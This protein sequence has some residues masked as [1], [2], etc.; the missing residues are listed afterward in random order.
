MSDANNKNIQEMME[1]TSFSSF[2][3]YMETAKEKLISD[4]DILL[5][6]E[7]ALIVGSLDYYLHQV[8]LEMIVNVLARGESSLESSLEILPKSIAESIK[9]E[10]DFWKRKD[11]LK[12]HLDD[13]IWDVPFL[14]EKGVDETAHFLGISNLWEKASGKVG[15]S[16]KEFKEIF[17]DAVNRRNKIVHQMDNNKHT[18]SK[19]PITIGDVKRARNVVRSIISSIEESIS[20]S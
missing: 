19:N 12:K 6:A 11:M 7:Y 8:R 3:K 5:R 17:N 9:N 4:I 13:T 18:G 14:S 15:V 2:Y 10:D 1:L 16:V 20:D